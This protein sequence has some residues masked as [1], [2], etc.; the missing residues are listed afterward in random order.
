M[1]SRGSDGQKNQTDYNELWPGETPSAKVTVSYCT[2]Q[3]NVLFK[4]ESLNTEFVTDISQ[5]V[6]MQKK[7]HPLWSLDCDFLKQSCHDTLSYIQRLR[8]ESGRCMVS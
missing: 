7:I 8:T 4:S 2:N 3:A 1:S 5:G 6:N